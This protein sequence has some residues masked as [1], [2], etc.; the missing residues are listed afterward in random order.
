MSVNF[1]GWP[2]NAG[3]ELR[4]ALAKMLGRVG[5]GYGKKPTFVVGCQRSGT[6]MLLR[7]LDRSP[8]IQVY[9][10]GNKRAFD[11]AARIRSADTL[12]TVINNSTR[13]IVILKPL[14]DTQRIDEILD[15]HSDGK[16]IWMYRHYEDVVNSL[17]TKWGDAQLKH[18]QE[19]A[20]GVYSGSGSRALGENMTEENLAIVRE[21]CNEDLSAESAAALIWYLRN[22]LFFDLQLD[23]RSNVLL[24]NYEDMVKKPEHGFR[25]VFGFIEGDLSSA[26]Y[27]DVFSS[28]IGKNQAP[29]IDAAILRLCEDMESRLNEHYQSQLRAETPLS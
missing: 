11:E 18:L 12:R 23:A 5:L 13:P 9:G 27:A 4:V 20:S 22:S 25:R 3:R 1:S 16:A 10:E 17:V 21:F 29:A 2:S 7:V 14:N 24:C 26:Y 8:Q 19:I 28:S 6:T 15:T